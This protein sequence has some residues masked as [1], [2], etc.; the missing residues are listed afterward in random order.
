MPLTNEKYDQHKIDRLKHFLADMREKG[1]VRPF[2]IFVDGLK[3]VPKTDDPKEFDNYEYYMNEDTEKIRIL[4]Y[5]SMTSPR[6]DQYCFFLSRSHVEKSLNGLGELDGIIQ[7]KLQARDREHE[8]RKMKEDLEAIKKQLEEA[9]E[10]AE[11]LERELELARDNKHKLGK[12]DLVEL[13]SFVLERVAAKN[14]AALEKFGLAGLVQPQVGP[15]ETAET[16]Q[17]SFTKKNEEPQAGN[18]ELMQYLPWLQQLDA[19]FGQP[20]LKIVMEVLRQFTEDPSRLQTVADL[21]NIEIP[22]T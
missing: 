19:A 4:I 20:D 22:N 3:V 17:A 6:N 7:E 14:A 21:L 10:Y 1:Q 13:G 16:T 18:P 12:L 9:E 5:Y 15:T 2:E 11:E 8:M